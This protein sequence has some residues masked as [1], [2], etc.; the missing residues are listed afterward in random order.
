MALKR[1]VVIYTPDDWWRDTPAFLPHGLDR[2]Y[3]VWNKIC[4]RR[5]IQLYRASVAWYRN[6]VFTKHWRCRPDGSW[7]KV[8]R[9]IVPHMIYDKAEDI[10]TDS[11]RPLPAVRLARQLMAD[12]YPVFNAPEFTNLMDNKLYQAVAFG[13][14][15]PRTWL[16]PRGA[17]VA[18]PGHDQLVLKRFYGEGGRHVLITDKA[19]V[20]LPYRAIR[21][22]FIPATQ[23]G[24]LKDV[25]IMYVGVQ[26]Q[27][28]FHRVA[29]KGSLYTNVYKGAAVE[30]VTLRDVARLLTFAKPILAKLSAFPKKVY[31]L[32]FLVHARRRQPYLIETNTVPGTDGFSEALLERLYTS[33]TNHFLS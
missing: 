20:R 19:R 1:L 10:E 32:D 6:G 16:V 17:T 4:R 28:A 24:V 2:A 18:N 33:I 25:R 21:Q 13:E 11:G 31:S 15:M 5:G 8:A 23:R 30:M 27:Y 26:P 14:F 3:R 22:E 9:S 12:R 7:E 29:V